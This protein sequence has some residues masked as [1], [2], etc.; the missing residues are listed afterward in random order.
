MGRRHRR[1]MLPRR[2][3]TGRLADVDKLL[4]NVPAGLKRT[5][6]LPVPVPADRATGNR[7]REHRS[8]QQNPYKGL[9]ALTETDAADFRGRK[10]CRSIDS[11]KGP[12]RPGVAG[13][14]RSRRAV[15]N[16]ASRVRCGREL[17]PALRRGDRGRVRTGG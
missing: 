1:W 5:I 3:E 16:Q 7:R 2:T 17:I 9:R 14:C 4:A 10:V 13:G 6:R 11:W 12:A 15:G 8:T